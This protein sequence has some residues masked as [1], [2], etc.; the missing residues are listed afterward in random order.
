VID[1]ARD[2][3]GRIS[4][5]SERTHVFEVRADSFVASFLLLDVDA[6]EVLEA[7]RKNSDGWL[8]AATPIDNE[9]QVALKR[10]VRANVNV[11]SV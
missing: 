7:L 5:G 4:R 2:S 3:A 9:H 6:R 10:A 11:L 8:L 1:Y